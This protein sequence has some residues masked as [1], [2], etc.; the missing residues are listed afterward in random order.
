L[1]GVPADERHLICAGNATRLYG[2]GR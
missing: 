2:F 1:N